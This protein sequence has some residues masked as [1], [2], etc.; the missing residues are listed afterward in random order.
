METGEERGRGEEDEDG[1]RNWYRPWQRA[2]SASLG[3]ARPGEEVTNSRTYLLSSVS[4]GAAVL[5]TGD[6]QTGVRHRV[7]IHPHQANGETEERGGRRGHQQGL[8]DSWTSQKSIKVF[9]GEDGEQETNT[10]AVSYEMDV[11]VF[12]LP[13]INCKFHPVKTIQEKM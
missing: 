1:S 4:A 11:P 8:K 2:E 3:S 10:A 7:G 13:I 5:V 6:R 9:Q 12:T